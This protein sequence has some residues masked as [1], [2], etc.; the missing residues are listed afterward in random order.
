MNNPYKPIDITTEKPHLTISKQKYPSRVLFAKTV[1]LIWLN[2]I[3][4]SLSPRRIFPKSNFHGYFGTNFYFNTSFKIFQRSYNSP[5]CLSQVSVYFKCILGQSIPLNLPFS[6]FIPNWTIKRTGFLLSPQPSL[7]MLPLSN[8]L[9]FPH[10]VFLNS[11]CGNSHE[12]QS[13]LLFLLRQMPLFSLM[14]R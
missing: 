2:D 4:S 8:Q 11:K 9:Q 14:L 3:N 7:T 12:Y 5:I 10:E 1:G 13:L 6:S